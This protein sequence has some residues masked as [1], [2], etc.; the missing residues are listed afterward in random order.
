MTRH[1]NR[2]VFNIFYNPLPRPDSPGSIVNNLGPCFEELHHIET[3][4]FAKCWIDD[5]LCSPLVECASRVNRGRRWLW[6]N[7]VLY[8]S[9]SVRLLVSIHVTKKGERDQQNIHCRIFL[10]SVH[11]PLS[12]IGSTIARSLNLLPLVGEGMNSW[13]RSLLS[14]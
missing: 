13:S 1:I 2:C 8:L 14:A 11:S 4:H 3:V 9:F 7:G 12:R 6:C 10:Y 5:P